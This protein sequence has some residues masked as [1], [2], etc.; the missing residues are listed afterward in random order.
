MVVIHTLSFFDRL[1]SEYHLHEIYRNY[2]QKII[3]FVY[4]HVLNEA[5][6]LPVIVKITISHYIP[7]FAKKCLKIY[8]YELYKTC[9]NSTQKKKWKKA[10]ARFKKASHGKN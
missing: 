5:T 9:F 8:V 4:H 1:K 7:V 10:K 6:D 2:A 3:F